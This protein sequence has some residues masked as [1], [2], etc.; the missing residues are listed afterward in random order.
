MKGDHEVEMLL[1]G[2]CLSL[3]GL[4][5]ACL[6]FGAATRGTRIEPRTAQENSN[7][8]QC[9]GADLERRSPGK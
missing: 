2:A 9:V 8:T 3:F 4:V 1:M 6:A 5:V 7:E